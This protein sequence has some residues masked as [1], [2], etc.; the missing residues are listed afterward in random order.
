M[1][2]QFFFLKFVGFFTKR[3]LLSRMQV[4]HYVCGYTELYANK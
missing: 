3:L 2:S 1:L 4:L